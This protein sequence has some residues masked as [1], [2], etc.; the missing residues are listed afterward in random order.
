MGTL[1]MAG[2]IVVI[3]GANSGI[4]LE[5]ARGL[6]KLG[7]E[8][9]MVCR[10]PRR[11]STGLDDVAKASI[12]PAP[13]LL[14]ADL[15][16]QAAIRTLS[17]ELHARYSRIDVLINNAGAAFPKRDLTADGIERTFA[18]NHLAPF[19][20]TNLVLDLLRSAPAARII[21]VSSDR[22]SVCRERV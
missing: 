19:L 20:L 18:V 13:R 16:S 9:V 7:A 3:T 21:G 12:G 17:A 22:K 2:Q 10:D 5:S 15:S 4:G 1:R 14:I 11:G 8:V 6:A